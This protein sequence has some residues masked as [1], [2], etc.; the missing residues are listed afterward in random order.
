MLG[1]VTFIVGLRSNGAGGGGSES[2]RCGCGGS[3][4]TMRVLEGRCGRGGG[5]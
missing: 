5:I 4:G 3:G 2:F 1:L